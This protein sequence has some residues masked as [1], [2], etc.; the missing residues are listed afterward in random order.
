MKEPIGREINNFLRNEG[1]STFG[2]AAV[3]NLTST[4]KNVL[5]QALMEDAKSVICYGIQIPKGLI[6]AKSSIMD[7][8]WRHCSIQYKTLD[9]IS[10]RLCLV[11]EEASCLAIP[12]YSC[13]PW[14]IVDREFWGTLPLVYWAEEAG[15]GRLSKCGLLIT[16][17]YG[18]RILLGGVITTAELEP[19]EKLGED[20]CP[21]DCH[22]CIDACPVKAIK[23]TGKIDH[24]LC[25]RHSTSNPLLKLALDN[26]KIQ[27][28]HSFEM[29]LN[30]IAVDDHSTYSCFECLKAC[31]LNR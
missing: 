22:D 12:I 20:I 9:S 18:T 5:P 21:S 11:L 6:Y 13:F 28:N 14:K 10:N 1:V 27:K 19:N 25:L 24:N 7:L 23:R 29:L 8:Y 2:V 3:K 30:T 4:P 17:Q 16:S 15:L 26:Q 31:P